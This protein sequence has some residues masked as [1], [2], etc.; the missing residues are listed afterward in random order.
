MYKCA[1]NAVNKLSR[2]NS[3]IASEPS[4]TFCGPPQDPIIFSSLLNISLLLF[5]LHSS[6][7]SCLFPVIQYTYSD[8]I[9][10]HTDS[11]S[12]FSMCMNTVHFLC[13]T[14][15][16]LGTSFFYVW[17]QRSFAFFFQVFGDLW[18]PKETMR[19]FAF[20]S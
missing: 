11:C 16:G 6:H 14:A 9:P 7:Y 10:V 3:F 4:Y 19:S 12:L 1:K 5:M 18:N 8:L 20:F 13:S 15:S 2:H 17:T